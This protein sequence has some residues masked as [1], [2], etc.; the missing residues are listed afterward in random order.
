MTMNN[1][2]I[3]ITGAGSGIGAAT[4]DRFAQD[5]AR[6]AALGRS[7]DEL[8]EKVDELKHKGYDTIALVADIAMPQQVKQ[9]VDKTIEQWGR[10]DY[11]FANA[12]VNGTWAPLPDLSVDEWRQT[13]DIN[14]NGTYYTIHHA[15]PHLVK[16]GGAIVI[17]ASINGTRT[18]TSQGATAYASTKAAQVAMAKMLAVELGPKN[19]RVNVVCPGRIDTDIDE[20]TDKEDYAGFGVPSNFPQGDIPMLGKGSGTSMQVANVVH[21]LCSEEGS[22]L[23]GTEIWVDGGQSLV[24]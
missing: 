6:I 24:K 4:A 11:V 9:A 3:L 2:V 21:F 5:G 20:N 16:Q 10:L 8:Q 12:G 22:L 1:R 15:Y 23:N 18:F 7:E 13:I 14:L 17:T 19:I